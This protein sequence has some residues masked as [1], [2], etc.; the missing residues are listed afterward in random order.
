MANTI[1]TQSG[2]VTGPADPAP[3]E[4]SPMTASTDV[5]PAYYY[6]PTCLA[7]RV[8]ASQQEV[9]AARSEGPWSRS[10]SE[11]QEAVPTPP[12]SPA[13]REGESDEPHARRSHR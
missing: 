6:A 4:E 5:W 8:F 9:T 7:G 1:L 2:A 13:T 3:E 10:L 12:E 11:A